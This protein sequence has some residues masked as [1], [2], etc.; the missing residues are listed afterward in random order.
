MLYRWFIFPFRRS[1]RNKLILIMILISVVPL[2]VVT[3]LS[4]ENTR[5]SMESEVI[6]SNI[7]RIT[8]TGGYLEEKFIQ[9]NNLIYTI[10]ISNTLDEYINKMDGSTLSNQFNA[11]RSIIDTMTSV[12]YS[13]NNHLLGIQLYLK[14]KNKLFTI[15]SMQ[16]QISTPPEVP[17]MW[18]EVT[19]SGMNFM[20]TSNESDPS[21]FNLIRSVNRFENKELLGSILLEVKWQMMD[22]A[23]ELLRSEPDYSVFI[24]DRDGQIMYMPGPE[25]QNE[26]P[27]RIANVLKKLGNT[28]SGPGYIQTKDSYIFYNTV[29]PWNLKLVKIIP[30]EY[31]NQSARTNLNYGLIVGIISAGVSLLIAVILAWSTSKPIVSLAK[32]MRGISIIQDREPPVS[33]RIDELGFLEFKLYN[34]SHRLR[35]YIKTEYSMNLEKKT[36]QLKALQSQINPHFLQ[37]TLQ[38]IGGLAFSSKPEEINELIRSL[39]HMFRYVVRGPNDLATIQA[40]LD[41]LNNYMHIQMQRFSPRISYEIECDPET[42]NCRIPKLTLQP[43]VENAFQH[44][45][46]KKP[47]DWRLKVQVRQNQHGVNILVEDNGVG[48]NAAALKELQTSLRRET[49]QIWTSGDRIGMNN[50]ASRIKMHFGL[51]YGVSVESESG[52]GTRVSIQIPMMKEGDSSYDQN[53]NRG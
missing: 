10:L 12:Y 31:I 49:D 23:L 36:A 7:T 6:Q 18:N 32:S 1:I 43:I 38:L 14:E 2:I 51:Q 29:E 34:M 25:N 13:G 47:G 22:S 17:A 5:K 53:V 39:S 20:I 40:E 26:A 15:N 19:S 9:L 45:L 48:M 42:L 24:A 30:A 28:D 50:V 41:H 27:E 21:K 16:K 44:G 35:E 46:D 3:V 8:W 37:N 33:K 4:A 11:Q 52:V